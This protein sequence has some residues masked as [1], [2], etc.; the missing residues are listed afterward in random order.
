MR[1]HPPCSQR[2]R[3]APWPPAVL[4]DWA[5]G[6]KPMNVNVVRPPSRSSCR[7]RERRNGLGHSREG[8]EIADRTRGAT[9]ERAPLQPVGRVPDDV[10]ERVFVSPRLLDVAGDEHGPDRHSLCHVVL[11]I[12]ARGGAP[13]RRLDHLARR[14][15]CVTRRRVRGRSRPSPA[16]AGRHRAHVVRAACRR[17]AA[18]VTSAMVTRELL[19]LRH[20]PEHRPPAV[21]L[22]GLVDAHAH[23]QT[24]NGPLILADRRPRRMGWV[25]ASVGFRGATRST[26]P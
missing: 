23:Q 16:P 2:G 12:A 4:A 13:R 8:A 21:N 24:T 17:C 5:S 3:V 6:S 11:V 9:S 10:P 19:D 20:R 25:M 22:P 15:E 26:S 18:K 1:R 7:G 14:A